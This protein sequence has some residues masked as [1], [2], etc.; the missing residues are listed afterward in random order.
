M[1]RLHAENCDAGL[2]IVYL[3]SLFGR[4]KQAYYKDK[5]HLTVRM[6]KE[7]MV[8]EYVK[9]EREE[10]PGLG[11][12]KLWRKYSLYYGKE[13]S[14]GRD[15][16]GTILY[17]HKLTLRKKVRHCRTT[18]SRH[19]Y[20]LY[21]NL[22]KGLRVSYFGQLIVSDITY[23]RIGEGFCFLSIVTDVYSRSIIGYCVGPTLEAS[24]TLLALKMAIAKL[25]DIPLRKGCIHH[26]DRGIQYASYGYTDVLKA[27]NIVISMTQSGDPRDN[28]IAERVN[29]ILKQ[30]FLNVYSFNC[31]EEVKEAVAN[32]VAYYNDQR[33]HRSLN[34][35]TPDIRS[36]ED[37]K[38]PYICW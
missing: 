9:K 27:N 22:I 17:A 25:K 12:E 23:I 35:D 14:M 37:E 7:Q 24:Y 19:P 29:G 16:F 18:D 33:L 5:N 11:G 13:Y 8:I 36:G 31:I 34:M 30:E 28:A 4:S 26:S 20:P 38:H 6:M 1:K 21:A 2:S 15:A 10:C 3:C 32:A